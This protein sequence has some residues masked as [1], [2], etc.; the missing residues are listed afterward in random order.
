MLSSAISSTWHLSAARSQVKGH[1]GQL[2]GNANVHLG[3]L[4]PQISRGQLACAVSSAR[5]RS[6]SPVLERP[7]ATASGAEF[8][9]DI[10]DRWWETDVWQA[11]P[12]QNETQPKNAGIVGARVAKVRA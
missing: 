9:Y 12:A 2:L 11:I 8:S 3:R 6:A 10:F 7:S 5:G 4:H 1:A